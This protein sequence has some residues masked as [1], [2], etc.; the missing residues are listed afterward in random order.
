VDFYLSSVIQ[1]EGEDVMRGSAGLKS[2]RI[3]DLGFS[4]LALVLFCPAFLFAAILVRSTSSGPI[5]FWSKRFGKD[6]KIFVMPKFRTME[7]NTPDIATDKLDDPAQ[8]ITK[9]GSILRKFSLDELPQ[10]WCVF[11]GEMSLVGPR[12]ALH[13]QVDLFE[14]RQKQGVN[15]LKPGLTGLAQINGRDSLTDHQKVAFDVL[16]LEQQSLLT[17]LRIMLLTIPKIAGRSGVS[18]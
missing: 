18:H 3:I 16:Y 9:V 11:T 13:T 14:L 5:I 15:A 4:S 7:I 12:P 2:K 8:Y 6:G 10:L 17:D 1:N